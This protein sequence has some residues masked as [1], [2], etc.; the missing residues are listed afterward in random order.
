CVLSRGECA[1]YRRRRLQALDRRFGRRQTAMDA[2]SALRTASGDADY[3]PRLRR[4]LECYWKVD[5]NAA[6]RIPPP[7]WRRRAGKVR[8]FHL[9]RRLFEF[10]RYGHGAASADAADL[11]VRWRGPAAEIR[12]SDARAHSDQA[13]L[14]KS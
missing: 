5:R 3:P 2:R 4:G 14:Q 7:D 6:A 1:R 9:R 10:H 12:L 13:R 8:A 11:Q